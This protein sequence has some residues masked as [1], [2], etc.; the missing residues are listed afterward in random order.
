MANNCM[1]NNSGLTG[2]NVNANNDDWID[3]KCHVM[4]T[5]CILHPKT[6][7]L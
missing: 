5:E 4:F 2:S 3:E 6:N 7:I 1:Y